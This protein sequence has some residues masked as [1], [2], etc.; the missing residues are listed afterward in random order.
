MNEL[1]KFALL[2][3]GGILMSGLGASILVGG[4]LMILKGLRVIP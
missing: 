2:Y 4:I 1:A 3:A